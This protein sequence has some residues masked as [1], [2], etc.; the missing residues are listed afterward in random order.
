MYKTYQLFKNSTSILRSVTVGSLLF[1]NI[2]CMAAFIKH[3]NNNRSVI[4]II[5]LNEQ[6]PA[7]NGYRQTLLFRFQEN[8]DVI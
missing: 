4:L 2:C 1:N 8:T 7:L 3:G 6:Q 5:G